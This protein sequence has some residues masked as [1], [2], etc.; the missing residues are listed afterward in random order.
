MTD[1]YTDETS[2]KKKKSGFFLLAQTLILCDESGGQKKPEHS[3][4]HKVA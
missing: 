4:D 3:L 2:L 1:N